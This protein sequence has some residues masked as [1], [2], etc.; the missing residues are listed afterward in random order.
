M[1][2]EPPDPVY[3]LEQAKMRVEVAELNRMQLRETTSKIS[4]SLVVLSVFT[5]LQDGVL[6]SFQKRLRVA[7][8]QRKLRNND[9]F[10]T[11]NLKAR[12]WLPNWRI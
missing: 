5:A 9:V 2:F 10:S 7:V 6:R 4:E 3:P 8:Q 12:H 1:Q 11:L